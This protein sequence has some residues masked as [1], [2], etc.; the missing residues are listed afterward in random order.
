MIVSESLSESLVDNK[1]ISRRNSK[2]KKE[3]IAENNRSS[4]KKAAKEVNSPAK[5]TKT[6]SAERKND[7][8]TVKKKATSS[9]AEIDKEEQPL[10]GVTFCITGDMPVERDQILTVIKDLGGHVTGNVSGRTTYLIA[11]NELEDGRAVTEGNKYKNAKKNKTSIISFSELEHLVQTTVKDS[12]FTIDSY[13]S[14]KKSSAPEKKSSVGKKQVQGRLWT[15]VFAPESMDEVIGNQANI[16]MFEEWLNDWN[17]VVL[18]GKTKPFA[19]KGNNTKNLNARACL[20]SGPPG[21]GKT[22]LVKLIAKL[23][24]YDLFELNASDQRN[25]N[26]IDYVVRYL[27]EN[28]TIGKDGN[29]NKT[30]ILM[31]EIDGMAGNEDRGGLAA[32]IDVIKNTKVPIVCICNDRYGKVRSLANYCLDLKF[33]KPQKNQIA[34]RLKEICELQ[35]CEI[36]NNSLELLIT[37]VGNDIRQC[38]NF[39]GMW[40]RDND[41]M[42]YLAMKEEHGRFGK[43]SLLMNSAFDAV[44]LLLNR[45]ESAAMSAREKLNLFF[46]DSDLVPAMMYVLW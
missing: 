34:K 2:N 9:A 33:S 20:I 11:G 41:S 18:K 16:K 10:S 15:D 35:G 3:E 5:N 31:D 22:T 37:S 7:H 44:R 36:D 17:S 42:D 6:K 38:L 32:I 46:I 25:K 43:D 13:A 8:S 4:S 12:S 39:L 19:F 30:L 27:S 24:Y 29:K 14:W 40:F 28:K 45:S 26:K 23:N 21:I 1:P